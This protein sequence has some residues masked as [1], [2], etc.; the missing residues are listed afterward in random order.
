MLL[1]AVKYSMKKK[2]LAFDLSSRCIGV[3]AAYVD[4]ESK[5]PI[6]VKSCPIIPKKFDCSILGYMKNK[7]KLITKDGTY[8]NTYFKPGEKIISKSEKIKRDREVRR[9]KDLYILEYI[10]EKI[11]NVINEIN[12]DYILVEK[13]EIFN[14]ILT[15]VLLSKILGVLF[16]AASS[17]GI[18]IEEIKVKTARSII[19]IKAATD[20]LLEN[21][22]EEAMSK[23]PDVTKRALRLDMERKFNK[24]GLECKTDDESD[25]CVVFNYWLE[26][27][28]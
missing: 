19:D 4:M 23:V 5:E 7:K 9:Y 17:K 18:R 2:I 8:V 1:M 20:R 15:T 6:I 25:A 26:E 21:I 16:G 13:N 27:I 3:V 28:C 14:G 11:S 12:P 24:Y 10:G 22:G